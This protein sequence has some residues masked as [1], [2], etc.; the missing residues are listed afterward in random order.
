MQ[1]RMASNRRDI[2]MKRLLYFLPT[3]LVLGFLAFIFFG[4]GE[5]STDP[6]EYLVGAGILFVFLI[7][8]RL[9]LPAFLS[10]RVTCVTIRSANSTH[11]KC[12]ITQVKKS[13]NTKIC[14]VCKTY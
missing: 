4:L 10:D 2:D 1:S 3:I 13:V 12:I 5:P 14:T 11:T 9:F 8:L 6:Q 7:L